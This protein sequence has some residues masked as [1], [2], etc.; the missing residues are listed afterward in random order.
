MRVDPALERQ[1]IERL[2]AMRAQRNAARVQDA[3]ARLA[4]AAAGATT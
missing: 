3:L 4:T 1:Q 2:R